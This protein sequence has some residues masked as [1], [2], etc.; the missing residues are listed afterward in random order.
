MLFTIAWRNIWR[1]KT[2]S[3]IIIASMVI[4]LWA[5]IFVMGF[6]NGMAESRV[7]TAIQ[8]EISHLQIH[9]EDFK[10]DPQPQFVIANSDSVLD[11]VRTNANVKAAS[12]RDVI[13]GMLMT[14]TSSNGVQIFGVNPTDESQTTQID[15]YVIEGNFLNDGKKNQ[16]V[17]GDKLATKMKLKLKSKIVLTFQ[18]KDGNLVSGAFRVSGIFKTDNALLNERIIYTNE[19]DLSALLGTGNDVHE[20]A[21]LLRSNEV[22]NTADEELKKQF[23]QLKVETWMEISP[24]TSIVL[25][26]TERFSTIFLIIILLALAFGIV[27]TMLMAILDRRRELGMMISLGM[28]R[29]RMFVMVV[30]ETFLLVMAGCPIGLLIGAITVETLSRKGMNIGSIMGKTMEQYGYSSIIYPK[31]GWSNYSEVIILVA[32]VAVFS[33]IFP[34]VKA[35]RLNPA[36]AIKL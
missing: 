23:P 20:I 11:V 5:G 32:C 19:K 34:A 18:D 31:M 14:A 35:M 28:N 30:Y 1:K 22:L 33:G 8:N 9:T 6:Y 4:G 10:N 15:K 2:R 16:V 13:A 36:T 3:I 12:G 25:G 24:E 7:K 21:I 27:N 26:S 17:I 29:I